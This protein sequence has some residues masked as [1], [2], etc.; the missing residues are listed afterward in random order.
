M[1]R[2]MWLN[3]WPRMDGNIL[4]GTALCCA[5]C[6]KLNGIVCVMI[7]EGYSFPEKDPD[8]PFD[9]ENCPVHNTPETRDYDTARKTRY[10]NY[11]EYER[12]IS[13]IKV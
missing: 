2:E 9:E 11:A 1:T 4:M 7:N 10:Q 13:M 3:G 5:G 12:R 6:G 8:W